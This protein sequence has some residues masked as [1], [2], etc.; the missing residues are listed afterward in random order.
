MSDAS[1]ARE[2]GPPRPLRKKELALVEKLLTG[3]CCETKARAQLREARVQD[4]PDGGMGSIR[5]VQGPPEERVF[6]REIAEG[7]FHD[8]DGV[9]VS[10]ALNIDQFDDLFEL[11]LWKVDFSPLTRYPDADEVEIIERY[12]K[13]GFP[14]D[15]VEQDDIASKREG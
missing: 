12:G 13:L 4:M 2:L 5:F 15:G 1:P 11:D 9:P 3:A 14:P 6:S 7:L 8:A 10:V